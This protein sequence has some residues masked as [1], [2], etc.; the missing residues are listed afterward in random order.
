MSEISS[1]S[2]AKMLAES[3]SEEALI[4][5]LRST[6]H[7]FVER[8]PLRQKG[9][10]LQVAVSFANSAP[11]GWPAALY[12]GVD[13]DGKPQIGRRAKQSY[14]YMESGRFPPRWS[15]P[16]TSSTRKASSR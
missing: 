10:W 7:D 3:L 1:N 12:V 8:K 4:L 6:E 15:S 9:D 13:D 2:L 5:R 11:I 14:R 16:F